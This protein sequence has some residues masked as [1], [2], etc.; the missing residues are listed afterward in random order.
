[1]QRTREIGIRLA[2]GARALGIVRTILSDTAGAVAAGA[3]GGLLG[4]WYL[5]RFVESL[6]FEVAPGDVIALV[7]PLATLVLAAALSA[8]LP[9]LRAAR[10][11][12]ATALRDE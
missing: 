8:L 7:V 2:L 4:G 1:V 5:S 11:D 12:P 3:A 10:L 6:V 9:A